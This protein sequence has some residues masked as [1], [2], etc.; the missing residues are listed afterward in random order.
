MTLNVGDRIGDYEIVSV[1]GAG[2]MGIV[3]LARHPRLPRS[4]ALKLLNRELTG[5]GE[6]KHLRGSIPLPYNSPEEPPHSARDGP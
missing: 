3:Y 6:A 1:L 5:D 2:G 4:I